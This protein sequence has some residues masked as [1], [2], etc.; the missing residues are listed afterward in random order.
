[1]CD[2]SLYVFSNRLARDGEELWPIDS[3]RDVRAS[4]ASRS[5]YD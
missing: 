2:Y 5:A 4:L 3:R 1:M